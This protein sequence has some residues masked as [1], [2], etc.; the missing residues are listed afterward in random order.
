M[1]VWKRYKTEDHP[2]SKNG[3][4]KFLGTHGFV[5]NHAT[6]QEVSTWRNEGEST[7]AIAHCA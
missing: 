7:F 5:Q 1:G 3:A 4:V 6:M 2:K